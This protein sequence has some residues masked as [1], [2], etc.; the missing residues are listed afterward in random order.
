MTQFEVDLLNA[1]ISDVAY[2]AISEYL[3]ALNLQLD[4]DSEATMRNE[5]P[6]LARISGVHS[7]R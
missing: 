2:E 6:Y 7:I 5:L 4:P 3:A 1:N